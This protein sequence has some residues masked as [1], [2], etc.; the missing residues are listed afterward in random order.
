MFRVDWL[1]SAQ[2]EL[3]QIWLSADSALRRQV[4]VSAQRIDQLLQVNPHEHGESRSEGRRVIFVQPTGRQLSGRSRC[5]VDHRAAHLA[6][7]ATTAPLILSVPKEVI[8]SE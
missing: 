2:N 4:S 6:V 8:N 3:A 5:K 1:L 7:S